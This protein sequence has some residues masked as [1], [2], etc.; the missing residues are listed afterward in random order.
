MKHTSP[1]F[2]SALPIKPIFTHLIFY[3]A[4]Q[5]PKTH[6]PKNA[7]H[8]LFIQIHFQS[9]Y[10][11]TPAKFSK[12]WIIFV[13]RP[14]AF[15]TIPK[16]LCR[17]PLFQWKP[18]WPSR[19]RSLPGPFYNLF[20]GSLHSVRP[21]YVDEFWNVVFFLWNDGFYR[22]VKFECEALAMYVWMIISLV[23]ISNIYEVG[24]TDRSFAFES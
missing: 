7:K 21:R 15:Q 13:A 5:L 4:G 9:N 17:G 18:K 16:H 14:V 2:F 12:T 22:D 6:L 20:I 3:I 8:I 19:P 11:K 1:K 23:Y 10:S 24:D